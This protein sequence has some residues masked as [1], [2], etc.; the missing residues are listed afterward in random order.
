MKEIKLKITTDKTFYMTVT[1]V[2]K[3]DLNNRQIDY[4]Y[5]DPGRKPFSF[6]YFEVGINEVIKI[7]AISGKVEQWEFSDIAEKKDE[8]EKE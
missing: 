3:T 5:Y 7:L 4:R 6:N 8:W 1:S 2:I